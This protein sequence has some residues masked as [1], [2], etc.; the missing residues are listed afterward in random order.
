MLNSK[1]AP[2]K[3]AA[4]LQITLFRSRKFMFNSPRSE[5]AISDAGQITQQNAAL[6]EETNASAQSLSQISQRLASLIGRFRIGGSASLMSANP[7]PI[8]GPRRSFSLASYFSMHVRRWGITMGS[9][10]GDV[11]LFL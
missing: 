6:M 8:S 10:R 9:L 3:P 7:Q 2:K 4:T 5:R 11:T 1:M